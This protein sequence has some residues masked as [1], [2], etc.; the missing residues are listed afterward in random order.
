LVSAL[1]ELFSKE[2]EMCQPVF[3]KGF[4]R[5]QIYLGFGRV[6]AV[7]LEIGNKFPLSCETT[8]SLRCSGLHLH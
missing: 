6:P 5:R 1:L 8:M 4:Q 2:R 3:L 7:S